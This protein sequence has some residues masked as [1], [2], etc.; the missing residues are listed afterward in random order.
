MRPIH[1]IVARVL[2]LKEG[3]QQELEKAAEHAC[4]VLRAQ[5]CTFL[6]MDEE[7]NTPCP[8]F[9]REKE[10]V[11]YTPLLGTEPRLA[12]GA[13]RC[14]R[15]EDLSCYELIVEGQ[16][17]GY[18]GV[19]GQQVEF[20]ETEH[21]KLFETIAHLLLAVQKQK[22]MSYTSAQKDASF[23]TARRYE[24]ALQL[25]NEKQKTIE[26]MATELRGANIALEASRREAE[27][28]NEA[29]SDF[30]AHMSH[31]IRTPLASVIATVELMRAG[32]AGDQESY[33]RELDS[34]CQHLI[35]LVSDVL[36][37][38][39]AER[40]DLRIENEPFCLRTLLKELEGMARPLARSKG[41]MLEATFPEANDVLYLSDRVRLRQ[42]LLN[43]L[44]NAIKFTQE[45]TVF[46]RAR[47]MREHEGRDR[48]MFEIEDQGCG[49]SAED[50]G[51][52]FEPFAQCAGANRTYLR[53]SGLGLSLSRSIVEL[54][55]GSIS[56]RSQ[57]E[58][59]ATFVVTVDFDHANDRALV[60]SDQEKGVPA[61]LS[62]LLA[63][64]NPINRRLFSRMLETLGCT[65]TTAEDGVDA[66]EAALQMTFDLILM[67]L[68]MP[69]LDG[70][71]AMGQ[72]RAAGAAPPMVA[73][74][75]NSESKE[76]RRA[77]QAG[78]ASFLVKPVSLKELREL[79]S[80]V[81]SLSTALP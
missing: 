81:R 74:S 1:E 56:V 15:S 62:V 51:L 67:D 25:G 71:E 6:I 42:V 4:K 36:D 11:R 40:G 53:G 9:R 72:I 10:P 63:D 76:R 65:V 49:I 59:G 27:R 60:C 5:G 77:K 52:I 3:A 7:I 22:E 61:G 35:T 30:L 38:A 39:K 55:G 24:N 70:F 26:C 57:P 18:L 79:L 31:E 34:S 64:D 23:E 69:R 20:D 8:V 17:T 54:M 33:L 80:G 21:L 50:L 14:F 45:G 2:L 37:S 29:K 16:V 32:I 43:L 75:A 48:V 58:M 41:L 12:L 46:L 44:S 68:Q 66:V 19:H 28:A 13:M 47:A 73:F 78:A